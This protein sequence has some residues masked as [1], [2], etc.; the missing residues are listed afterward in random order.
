MIPLLLVPAQVQEA[1]ALPLAFPLPPGLRIRPDSLRVSDFDQE[2]FEIKPVG[3]QPP[4][5]LAVKGKTWRFLLESSGARASVLS[6][7]QIL[8]PALAAGGWT[9]QWEQRGVARYDREARTF[10]A[11]VSPAGSAALGVVLVQPGQPRTITLVRP[12]KTP[13]IPAPDKDFPYVA[14]WPG[15]EL[16]ATASSQSPVIA[17]LGGGKQGFAMVRWIEKEYAL[18][19]PPS[20]Q[21]FVTSYRQALEAAGWEIEGGSQG[22]SVQIQAIYLADGRDIRLTLRLVGDAMAVSVADVGAQI[23]R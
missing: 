14:P 6:L 2:N 7:Q 8:K 5:R 12:G 3:I 21:E 23:R 17:D 15:A 13:E 22:A 10:W 9:W 20:P 19:A 1:P 16:V 18:P 11:K 4:Q